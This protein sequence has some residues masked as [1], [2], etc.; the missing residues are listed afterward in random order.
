MHQGPRPTFGDA[1]RSIEAHLFDG[2]P[3]LY[4]HEVK[5]SWVAR[6]REVRA[7]PSPEALKRQL[8]RDLAAARGA[9]PAPHGPSSP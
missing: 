9:L 4:G 5:L 8:D 6:L 2:G 3:D 7:F 1:Q